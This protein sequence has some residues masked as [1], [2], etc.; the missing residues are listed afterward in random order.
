M[1]EEEWKGRVSIFMIMKLT[2]LHC[3]QQNFMVSS[4]TNFPWRFFFPSLAAFQLTK[5]SLV[6]RVCSCTRKDC[7]KTLNGSLFGVI[8]NQ[9]FIEST[10]HIKNYLVT[11]YLT[12]QA[13]FQSWVLLNFLKSK[14]FLCGIGKKAAISCFLT[15]IKP[16]AIQNTR[17]FNSKKENTFLIAFT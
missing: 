13:I 16:W 12:N 1:K 17:N 8:R 4:L 7:F 3:S 2:E 6:V 5:F 10:N 14:I 11:H 9:Y 15:D